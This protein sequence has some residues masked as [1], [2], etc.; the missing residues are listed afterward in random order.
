[1]WRCRWLLCLGLL[2]PA[3]CQEA[4]PPPPVAAEVTPEE[5]QQDEDR[6]KAARE[7]EQRAGHGKDHETP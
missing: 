6:L 2:G 5:A 1:M 3:G 4:A 7:A